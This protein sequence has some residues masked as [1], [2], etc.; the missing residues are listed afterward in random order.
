MSERERTMWVDWLDRVIVVVALVCLVAAAIIV[1][2][3]NVQKGH[4]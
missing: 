3:Y 1:I 4:R 2:R